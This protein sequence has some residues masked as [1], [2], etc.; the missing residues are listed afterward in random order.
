MD[1]KDVYQG[2]RKASSLP[3]FGIFDKEFD[4]EGIQQ[5]SSRKIAEKVMEKLSK[6][7][8]YLEG[9]LHGDGSLD[10]LMEMKAIN[11]TDKEGM[12][13]CYKELVM[14]DRDFMLADLENKGFDDFMK[15][16]FEKWSE[17]KPVLSQLIK[18]TKDSWK[19]VSA[20]QEELGYLG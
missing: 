9:F 20:I 2:L 12:N 10:I 19:E 8:E 3:E 6:Y 5:P 14:I 1:I 16:A 13:T 18:K 11:D 7:R 4:I 15:N 17:L